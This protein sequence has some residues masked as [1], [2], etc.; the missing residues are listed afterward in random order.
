MPIIPIECSKRRGANILF[1]IKTRLLSFLTAPTLNYKK[2]PVIINNFNRLTYLQELLQWLE[3]AGMTNIHIIDNQS[4]YK[5]LLEFYKKL[6]Y[7]VYRLDT[8]IGHTALWDTVLFKRF[9]K[10]YYVYT[11]PD[12]VPIKACNLN[13]VEYFYSLLQKYPQICKVGFGL[14]IDDL[15]DSYPL[16]EKVLQWEKKFW[17]KEVEDRVYKALID[18][19]FALYR[20]GVSGGD[21]IPA[22]RTGGNLKARHL[23]WYEDPLNL[24]EESAYYLNKVSNASSWYAALRGNETSYD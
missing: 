9:S 12:V 16:K 8:N 24:T 22:L 3:S 5:P 23:P 4:D 18:T 20:P 6:P 15:P 21:T 2:F 13:V 10:G 7:Q 1:R 19:T 14:K 11:D 17:E